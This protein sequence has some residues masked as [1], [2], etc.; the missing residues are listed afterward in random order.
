MGESKQVH[1][2]NPPLGS[3]LFL[4]SISLLSSIINADNFEVRPSSSFSSDTT[5]YLFNIYADNGGFIPDA[6]SNFVITFPSDYDNRLTS[7][8]RTCSLVWDFYAVAPAITCLVSGSNLI[9]SNLFAA[10]VDYTSVYFQI[11]VNSI[12]NPFRSGFTVSGYT[13]TATV[14]ASNYVIISSPLNFITTT[15]TCSATTSPSIVNQPGVINLA[16]TPP[17]F[18]IGSTISV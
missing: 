7:G 2:N 14:A 4:I 18:P 16:F 3:L 11:T 8:A 1:Y 10:N 5:N 15:M 13:F 12:L 9:I 6:N 17:Y